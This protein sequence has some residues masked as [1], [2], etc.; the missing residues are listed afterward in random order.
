MQEHDEDS[1]QLP[2]MHGEFVP[3]R[4]E[5]SGNLFGIE[6]TER[7]R[8]EHHTDSPLLHLY[9]EDDTSWSI[10]TSFDIHWLDDLINQLQKVKESHYY[11][12]RM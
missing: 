12:V 8:K 6:V 1:M 3:G 4:P 9:V 11:K 10:K 5:F 2:N 7:N